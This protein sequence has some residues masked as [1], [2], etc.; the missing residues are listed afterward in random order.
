ME[1]KKMREEIERIAVDLSENHGKITDR[2]AQRDGD[3]LCLHVAMGTSLRL[4]ET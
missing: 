3:P 1:A 4:I 2:A